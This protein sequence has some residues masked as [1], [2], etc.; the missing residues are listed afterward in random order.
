MKKFLILT[1]ILGGLTSC[2]SLLDGLA[3]MYGGGYGGSNY[4]PYENFWNNASTNAT[5]VPAALNP[6]TAVDAAYKS[7][8]NSMTS[9]FW[10]NAAKDEQQKNRRLTLWR[11]MYGSTLKTIRMFQCRVVV[12]VV[13]LAVVLYLV[14]A[15]PLAHEA[16][17]HL[18]D[19][20]TC[21]TVLVNATP[22]MVPAQSG[23]DMGCLEKRNVPTAMAAE[24]VQGVTELDAGKS[25][26][27]L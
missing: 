9:G 24:D 27:F 25:S 12:S 5:S 20:M 21:A 26:Q 22:A 7:T 1:F 15:D 18:P 23:K 4:N 6:N 14:A 13:L 17:R 19:N 3:S 11:K 10:E 8:M 2:G 16:T